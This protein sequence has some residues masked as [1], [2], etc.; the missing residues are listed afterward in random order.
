MT[1][2]LPLNYQQMAVAKTNANA[3]SAATTPVNSSSTMTDRPQVQIPQVTVGGTAPDIQLPNGDS[4]CISPNPVT[5]PADSVLSPSSSLSGNNK[6]DAQMSPRHSGGSSMG[7]LTTTGM[8]AS[9]GSNPGNQSLGSKICATPCYYRTMPDN[10]IQVIYPDSNRIFQYTYSRTLPPP[11]KKSSTQIIQQVQPDGTLSEEKLYFFDPIQL[12]EAGQNESQSQ[13]TPMGV[14]DMQGAPN[15]PQR[16][17]S[18]GRSRSDGASMEQ[19]S[20]DRYFN[21]SQGV[22]IDPQVVYQQYAY[23]RDANESAG[24]LNRKKHTVKGLVK[25]TK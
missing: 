20:R 8:N 18:L 9:A 11:N 12:T 24:W 4:T 13:P 23:T 25:L 17:Q 19:L 1:N 2:A 5:S 22:P 6:L 21:N 16:S 3:I 10:K 15:R 14:A 7:S